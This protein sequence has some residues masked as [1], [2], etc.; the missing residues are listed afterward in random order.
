MIR[1]R[2]CY[3]LVCD[4]CGRSCEHPDEEIVLHN[5]TVEQARGDGGECGWT[6]EDDLDRCPAC[7]CRSQ[8]HDWPQEWT[9]PRFGYPHAGIEQRP[10]ERAVPGSEATAC[11][12]CQRCGALEVQ[13][14]GV[15][16]RG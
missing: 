14:V 2:T 5:V 16:G 15:I 9:L 8:D 1:E 7:T 12:W 4:G 6:R 3:V 13:G 10:D 11:R